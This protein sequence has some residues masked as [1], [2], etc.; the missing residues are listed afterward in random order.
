MRPQQHRTLN[1]VLAA[2]TIVVSL[3]LALV[4]FLG[5]RERA[6]PPQPAPQTQCGQPALAYDGGHPFTADQARDV[7]GVHAA[8]CA[9]DYAA[10]A[11]FIRSVPQTNLP[12]LPS[13]TTMVEEWR[14]NDPTGVKLRAVA[15]VLEQPGIGH[16]GGLSFCHPSKGHVAFSRGTIDMPPGLGGFE[17]PRQGQ[18]L[19]CF[20]L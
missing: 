10:L 3:A 4:L 11:P 1:R 8:A 5:D 20:F 9:G 16:Q 17:F 2:L 14:S 19:D 15:S 12:T 18:P 13:A 7:A 6:A